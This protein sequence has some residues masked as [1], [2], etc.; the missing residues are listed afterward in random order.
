M[1]AAF[2]L[3]RNAVMSTTYMCVTGLWSVIFYTLLHT[4]Y[5]LT[6]EIWWS[7]QATRQCPRNSQFYTLI[8]KKMG[9]FAIA[10]K[11]QFLVV[12]FWH[13]YTCCQGTFTKIVKKFLTFIYM[14]KLVECSCFLCGTERAAPHVLACT[15]IAVGW[16][17]VD[18]ELG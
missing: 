9:F 12:S 4:G 14:G 13:T 18:K 1:F 15:C 17:N 16:V 11:L 10:P 6:K 7:F 8:Q 2:Q 5:I 3:S